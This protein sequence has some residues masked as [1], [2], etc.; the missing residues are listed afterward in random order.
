MISMKMKR[1]IILIIFSLTFSYVFS[2]SN[3]DISIVNVRNLSFGLI[4]PG[5]SSTVSTTSP[6]AGRVYIDFKKKLNCICDIL[7]A[8]LFDIRSK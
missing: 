8:E 6:N 7:F 4:V 2:Q 1:I 5:I 3:K